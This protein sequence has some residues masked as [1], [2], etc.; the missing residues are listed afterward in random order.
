MMKP[1]PAPTLWSDESNSCSGKG[2]RTLTW[3]GQEP[4]DWRKSALQCICDSR[5]LAEGTCA[6][7]KVSLDH[8][9]RWLLLTGRDFSRKKI[10]TNENLA[11]LLELS[12][13]A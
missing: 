13:V 12:M 9:D 4:R 2:E 10:G 3:L 5:R 1:T 6:H 7:L 8:A 11:I